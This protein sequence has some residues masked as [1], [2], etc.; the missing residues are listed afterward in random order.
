MH[1][2]ILGFLLLFGLVA[3]QSASADTIQNCG[4]CGGVVYTL[5]VTPGTPGPTL[6]TEWFNFA[7]TVDTTHV[8]V[9]TAQ[10]LNAVALKDPGATGAKLIGVTA[11]GV[12]A[13][14][15]TMVP[16]GTN[17]GGTSGTG[18]VMNTNNGWDCAQ[19][20]ATS[21]DTGTAKGVDTG[22]TGDIYTFTFG[23]L[24]PSSSS[25]DLA[26][27]VGLKA[28]YDTTSGTYGG[29]QTSETFAAPVPEPNS[30]V[31]LGSGLLGLAFLLRRR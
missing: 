9:S 4:S 31:L 10:V 22:S 30:L 12:T 14:S 8:S 15:W 17:N 19:A 23:F 1:R 2:Y 21:S 11:G 7:L 29:L 5:N 25:G 13:G 20:T 3:V 18:C 6:G 28:Y 16:G 26:S 27:G 24:L